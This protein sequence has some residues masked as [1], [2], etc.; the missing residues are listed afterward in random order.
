MS[1]RENLENYSI[2]IISGSEQYTSLVKNSLPEGRFLAIDQ[3][4]N[5]SSGQR[6]VLERE[7]DF[8]VINT[9]LPDENGI[10]LALDLAS[11]NSF[12]VLVLTPVEIY[13]DVKEYLI[14]EGVFVE[15]KPTDKVHLKQ[16]LR[17]LFGVQKKVRR[18]K[19]EA[20]E[21]RRKLEENKI[22]TRAKFILIEDKKMTEDEA[23]RYI[24][25]IAMDHGVSRR[26]VA[27]DIIESRDDF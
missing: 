18:A 8:V 13:E 23:H 4:K 16:M 24:G 21:I 22:V 10:E 1:M 3:K 15:R 19:A 9:P 7:Y 27:E 25:K 5:A 20:G 11:K 26:R 2:L 12:G 14:N 17:L 6:S